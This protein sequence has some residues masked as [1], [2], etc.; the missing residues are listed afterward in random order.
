M[1]ITNLYPSDEQQQYLDYLATVPADQR[2]ACKWAKFGECFGTCY[3]D[4]SK[5]GYVRQQPAPEPA[6]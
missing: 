3:G 1:A 2:C 6:P 4:E 5:G